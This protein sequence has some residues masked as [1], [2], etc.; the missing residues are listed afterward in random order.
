MPGGPEVRR[1]ADVLA[2]A[3]APHPLLSLAER[4]GLLE[5]RRVESIRSHGKNLVGQIEGGCYFYS[6]LMMRGHGHVFAGDAPRET[7]K[8]ARPDRRPRGSRRAI[9]RARL[10]GRR[11]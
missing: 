9:R 2:A 7:D 3:S 1:H 11:G 6:H 8:R 4:P 10:R 5:G